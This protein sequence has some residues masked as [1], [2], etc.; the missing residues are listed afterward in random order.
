MKILMI[1]DFSNFHG[2]LGAELR[3]RGHDVT[4]VSDG[5]RYM[6]T[7][8]D[9]LLARRP[10]VFGS[11]RYLAEVCRA[12]RS[13]KGY[14]VVQIMSPLFLN[15]RPT[16]IR[17][18]FDRLRRHNRRVCLTFASLDACM[19]R[20]LTE[21]EMF[22]YSEF[23]V[24][25]A[26]APL[27]LAEPETERAWTTPLMLDHCRH[28]L[29][30]CD[31]VMTALYEYHRVASESVPEKSVYAGI[32]V[33]FSALPPCA[34]GEAVESGRPVS[35]F[36]GRKGD[37]ALYKGTDILL[38]AAREVERTMPGKC[39]VTLAENLPLAE[40]LRRLGEADIVLDQIYSYTPAT[41]ALQAMAM[42]KVAVTGAEP[43]Y[44]NFIGENNLH[45]AVNVLPDRESIV[46]TLRHL[47]EDG[48]ERR[49]LRSEGPEFV[50][51]HNDVRVVADRFEQAW[52]AAGA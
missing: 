7:G 26:P 22:R 30:A 14:D 24:G 49:R 21:G 38:E 47:V 11:L 45:P 12:M 48:R 2:C 44:Y 15:L 23:R 20:I 3:R 6:Q 9:I 10:G 37:Y 18:V 16:L 17:R 43:E 32:P 1:G 46:A 29:G 34:S 19:V 42:G 28:V 36:I 40:Y 39:S 13:W 50:R 35:I 52:R 33:D 41:N 25:K 5:G 4:L 31:M 8:S 51:K 27:A